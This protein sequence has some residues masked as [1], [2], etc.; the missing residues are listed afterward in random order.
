MVALLS[1]Y[2]GKTYLSRWILGFVPEH[3]EYLELFGGGAA[4]LFAKWPSPLETYND[5]DSGLCNLFRVLRDER[6]WREFRRLCEWTLYS[7][8]EYEHQ[9][10]HWQEAETDV[11]RAYGFFVV[12]R[13]CFSGDMSGGW[14]Y[15]RRGNSSQAHAWASVVEEMEWFHRRL[16]FVQ[17]ENLDWR[18]ALARY[19]VGPSA[20][21][22]A[23]PPYVQELRGKNRYR[24]EIGDEGHG[25]LVERLLS[26]RSMVILSG[27]HHPVYEPLLAAGWKRYD[28]RVTCFSKK[29]EAGEERSEE[30]GY[31]RVESLYL[32]PL[33]QRARRGYPLL[34]EE[35][36]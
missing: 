33:A 26:C 7:R 13:S 11:E 1:W 20:L 22:Y 31:K 2:G 10:R 19:D 34:S 9:K 15:E 21:I 29:V 23:D 16:R 14:R 4:L 8:E 25:E 35:G 18:D 28:R 6:K 32:N 3:R 24:Y 27:Y 36:G 30:G 5:I 12:A 17:V